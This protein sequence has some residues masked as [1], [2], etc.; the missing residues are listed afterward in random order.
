M[1][2]IFNYL[3]GCSRRSSVA[4]VLSL[5]PSRSKTDSLWASIWIAFVFVLRLSIASVSHCSR[6]WA[7][8]CGIQRL[9][10]CSE[11]VLLV[12]K[13]RICVFVFV[14]FF[15]PLSVVSV[16]FFFFCVITGSEPGL[17][18]S[19]IPD[20][21]DWEGAPALENWWGTRPE[22][23]LLAEIPTL[24]DSLGICIHT[25]QHWFAILIWF[26]LFCCLNSCPFIGFFFFFFL[27][28][29]VFIFFGC[30]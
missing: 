6:I 3:C 25:L 15:F 19:G 28:F 5:P 16:F 12:W 23:F 4:F 27:P 14:F 1:S 18:G 13:S 10:F 8:I 30:C 2:I 11:I 21:G 20:H 26:L 9:S 24:R 7:C 22:L 17:L 29:E